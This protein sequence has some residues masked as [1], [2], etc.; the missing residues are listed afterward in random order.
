M[1]SF[2]QRFPQPV[3]KR[4][5]WSL[6]KW[7]FVEPQNAQKIVAFLTPLRNDNLLKNQLNSL[8]KKV[9]FGRQNLPQKQAVLEGQEGP[10]RPGNGFG[11]SVR[12][13]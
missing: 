4:H 6:F 7:S 11:V 10:T 3:E 12:A 8:W 13:N 2:S 5:F 9:F 1:K